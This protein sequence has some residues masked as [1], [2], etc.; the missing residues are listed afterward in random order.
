MSS[1]LATLQA[2]LDSWEMLQLPADSRKMTRGTWFFG[3]ESKKLFQIQTTAVECHILPTAKSSKETLMS[4]LLK[5]NSTIGRSF[6]KSTKMFENAGKKQLESRQ[7]QECVMT[8]FAISVE[9][10]RMHIVSTNGQKS[11]QDWQIP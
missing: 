2:T 5:F 10:V 11:S 7:D 1:F 8:T 4:T 9:D 6:Q 3:P